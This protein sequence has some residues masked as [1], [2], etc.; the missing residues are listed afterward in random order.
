MTDTLKGSF[1][2]SLAADIKFIRQVKLKKCQTEFIIIKIKF[3]TAEII[4]K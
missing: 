3:E 4:G 1:V 2:G